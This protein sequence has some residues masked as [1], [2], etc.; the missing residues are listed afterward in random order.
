[1][2]SKQIYGSHYYDASL[3]LTI[4]LRDGSGPSPATYVAYVNRSRVDVFGGLFGGLARSLVSSKAKGTVSD[5][6]ARLR[7]VLE[8][9]FASLPTP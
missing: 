8:Q 5:Q 6:L 1:V 2:A 9:R 4:L 3:G 7:T